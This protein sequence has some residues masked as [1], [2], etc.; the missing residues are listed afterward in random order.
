MIDN[1]GKVKLMIPPMPKPEI[2]LTVIQRYINS[3]N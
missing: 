2:A 3:L 1:T